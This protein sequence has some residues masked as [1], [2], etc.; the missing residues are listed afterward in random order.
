MSMA[1][2]KRR[3]KIQISQVWAIV[4]VAALGA[5]ALGLAAAALTPRTSPAAT[6]AATPVHTEADQP[7]LSVVGDS[8]TGGSAMDSGEDARWPRLLRDA[9]PIRLQVNAA[10]G[11]GYNLE[12]PAN[13]SQLASTVRDDASVVIVFG[14]LND[15]E[16]YD[17]TAEG[18]RATFSRSKSACPTRPS[19]SSG[20][21][22]LRW[23]PEAASPNVST[24]RAMRCET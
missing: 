16:G 24:S 22:H 13:F 7:W 9:I 18:A 23:Q 11:N 1:G 17:A 20:R 14:S 12:D 5:G 6:P 19:S 15:Q 10:G 4:L 8:Y 21:L 3:K 2:K